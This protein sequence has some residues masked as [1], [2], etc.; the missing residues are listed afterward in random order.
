MGGLNTLQR[1]VGDLQ[2]RGRLSPFPT[3]LQ[4][5]D[6]PLGISFDLGGRRRADD[7][8]FF[9]G[10][11]LVRVGKRYGCLDK[12]GHLKARKITEAV[13]NVIGGDYQRE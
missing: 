8:G 3:G 10:C 12:T 7:D 5:V 4:K 9:E 1:A 2:F 11:A 6:I 13:P